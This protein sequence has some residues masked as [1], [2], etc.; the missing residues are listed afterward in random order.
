MFMIRSVISIKQH[1][2]L[3]TILALPSSPP[4]WFIEQIRQMIN[5]KNQVYRQ[6][7]RNGRLQQLQH[8][9]STTS[10]SNSLR[11]A[12]KILKGRIQK[13]PKQSF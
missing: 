12:L 6:Y 4:S 9:N 1:L 5:N 13:L 10:T 11:D 7:I 8:L 2:T 3:F